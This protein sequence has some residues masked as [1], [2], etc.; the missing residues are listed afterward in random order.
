[1]VQPISAADQLQAGGALQS[2]RLYIEREEDARLRRLL[3]DGEFCHVLAP[4]QTGKTSLAKRAAAHLEASGLLTVQIDFNERYSPQIGPEDFYFDVMRDIATRLSLQ[5]D[6]REWID[7]CP[8]RR[9]QPFFV[10]FLLPRF[11][12]RVVVFLDEFDDLLEAS[13]RQEFLL[14][15]RALFNAR[16]TSAELSRVSFCLI[17]TFPTEA[18]LSGSNRSAFNIVHQILLSDFAAD[19]V[20]EFAALMR[21]ITPN[22]DK[23]LEEVYDLTGGHPYMLQKMLRE[24]IRGDFLPVPRIRSVVTELARQLFM[25]NRDAVVSRIGKLISSDVASVRS[26]DKLRLYQALWEAGELD[27]RP[28]EFVQLA[29]RLTGAAV[30]QRREEGMFLAVRNRVVADAFDDKWITAK[31]GRAHV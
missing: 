7:T 22:P 15:L 5:D 10:N 26:E 14:Q 31:I 8:D 9:L 1:M 11:A 28:Q 17:G 30:I 20:K 21:P 12:Q 13:F 19:E 29:L 3:Q 6:F 4:S 16:S 25:P 23:L 27:Y 18:F 24:L 2:T